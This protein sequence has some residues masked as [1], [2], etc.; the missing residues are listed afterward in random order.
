MLRGGSSRGWTSR[1]LLHL[2][3]KRSCSV[4]M[5]L[6]ALAMVP[7]PSGLPLDTA[8]AMMLDAAAFSHFSLAF[9]PRLYTSFSFLESAVP[10]F[11]L[12]MLVCNTHA[13]SRGWN[14]RTVRMGSGGYSKGG[15]KRD[16]NKDENGPLGLGFRGRLHLSMATWACT[17]FDTPLFFFFFL[18]FLLLLIL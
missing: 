9:C 15:G 18:F 16:R 7:F 8:P 5:S 1:D 10:L 14:D 3:S 4:T 6:I 2:T 17:G 11:F 13:P 12:H